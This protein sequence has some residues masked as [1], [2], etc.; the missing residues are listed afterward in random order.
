MAS[1]KLAI[2]NRALAV[3]GDEPLVS[4]SENRL[5]CQVGV[6]NYDTALNSALARG[7]WRF[8]TVKGELS[9]I[10]SAPLNE[11]AHQYQMPTDC[12]RLER[13][14]P[15][16][17]Y[18]I[19]RDRILTN[20]SVAAADYV[21]RDAQTEALIP[22]HF[23]LYLGFE[24]AVLIAPALTGSAATQQNAEIARRSN[25]AVSL[26]IDSQQRPNRRFVSSPFVTARRGM[27]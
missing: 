21:V 19:Y 7:P 2:I 15:D 18:E 24:L 5:A 8:A 25:L 9:K 6:E 1:S 26:T 14:Y 11:W 3:L 4:L 22:P 12:L 23:E 17:P 20:S 27:R 16:Q 10:P 13:L